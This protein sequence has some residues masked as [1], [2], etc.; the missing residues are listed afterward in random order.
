MQHSLKDRKILVRGDD[1]NTIGFDLLTV[2]GLKNLHWG[3][4][5][6]EF[7]QHAFVGWIQMLNDHESESGLFGQMA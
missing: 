4:P 7:D 2:P 1:V 3:D 6:E 5:G